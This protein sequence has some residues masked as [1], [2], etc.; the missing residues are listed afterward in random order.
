MKKLCKLI[1]ITRVLSE[2]NYAFKGAL[3]LKRQADRGESEYILM[4]CIQQ[5]QVHSE[6]S[7]YCGMCIV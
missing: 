1:K 6:G 5:Q 3:G 7:Q 4:Y 2:A